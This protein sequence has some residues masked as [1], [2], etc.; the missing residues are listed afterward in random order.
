M[1]SEDEINELRAQI[2]TL[3][4]KIEAMRG[5]LWEW[6]CSSDNVWEYWR[7]KEVGETAEDYADYIGE[8]DDDMPLFDEDDRDFMERL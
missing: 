7:L 6:N 8:D 3:N 2:F 4:K 5:V 1:N